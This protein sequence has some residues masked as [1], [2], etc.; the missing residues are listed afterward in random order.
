MEKNWGDTL[1]ATL[2]RGHPALTVTYV[3]K[4]KHG[5]TVSQKYHNF[6]YLTRSL[7]AL[8]FT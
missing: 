7:E 5:P 6:I 3:P 4:A 2:T 1:S 8:K